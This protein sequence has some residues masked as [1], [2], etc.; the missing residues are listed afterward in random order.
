M[1]NGSGALKRAFVGVCAGGVALSC[2]GIGVI[3]TTSLKS[4]P[5][6]IEKDIVIGG[7]FGAN[8]KATVITVSNSFM[9]TEVGLSA[10]EPTAPAEIASLG[11]IVEPTFIGARAPDVYL[12]LST[13]A[14]DQIVVGAEPATAPI[15]APTATVKLKE[16]S[17][18]QA[19][20]ADLQL[21][22]VEIQRGDT[23]IKALMRGGLEYAE[24]HSAA[25][26]VEGDFDPR[27]MQIGDVL[28]LG[29]KDEALADEQALLGLAIRHKGE[30][31]L[32]AQWAAED[33]EAASFEAA[34]E[35]ALAELRELEEFKP[36]GP[37][38]KPGPVFI[39]TE[40]N[41]S[42]YQSAVDAG[43]SPRQVSKLTRIFGFRVDFQRSIR[44]GDVME[45]YFD[46]AEDL[47]GEVLDGPI[48]FAR[49]VNRGR[50]L[51]YYRQPEKDG[52][53]YFNADGGI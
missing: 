7:A 52:G 6:T 46:R 16:T 13:A 8:R 40:I 9:T 20:D 22:D 3:A 24:A 38:K 34:I 49:L 2:A 39:S 53:G 21:R 30:A 50:D 33:E 42:L 37:A 12:E 48:L 45:V 25:K 35:V 17:G 32:A 31:E 23:M 10:D 43:L 1:S 51:A 15:P 41:S 29:F 14:P 26:A 19:E 18:E 11:P 5:V 27:R 28:T 44:K 36:K 47:H 4:T